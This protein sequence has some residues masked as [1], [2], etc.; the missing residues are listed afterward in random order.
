MGVVGYG[1]SNRSPIGLLSIQL[2]V[3][4]EPLLWSMHLIVPVP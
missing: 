4:G 2:T 3:V 1:G